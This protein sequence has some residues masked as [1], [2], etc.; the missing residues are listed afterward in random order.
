MNPSS[1]KVALFYNNTLPEHTPDMP[2]W[3]VETP[4]PPCEGCDWYNGCKEF[5]VSCPA[6]TAY[7]NPQ[8]ALRYKS[9]R[10]VPTW[11]ATQELRSKRGI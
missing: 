9:H 7:M 5:A 3:L 11:R 10:Q 8:H 2:A 1:N 6:F 4:A